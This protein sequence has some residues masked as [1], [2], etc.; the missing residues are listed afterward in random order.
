ME[1][2]VDDHRD[3]KL[4]EFFRECIEDSRVVK[5]TEYLGEGERL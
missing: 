2:V 5:V 4:T 1:R 3:V